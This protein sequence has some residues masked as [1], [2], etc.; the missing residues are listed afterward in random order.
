MVI[1]TLKDQNILIVEHDELNLKLF[2]DL[3][4]YMGLTPLLARTGK[5]A[6]EVLNEHTPD[7]TLVNMQLPDMSGYKLIERLSKAPEM[8][9]KP[10][11][12]L[13][14]YLKKE[15]KQKVLDHGCEDYVTKPVMV[16]YLIDKI[17]KTLSQKR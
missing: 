13:S 1:K 8:A 6:L 11:I 5:Q 17:D 7:L 2:Q 15:E 9:K 14:N 10:I 16:D 3:T 12:A 4:T